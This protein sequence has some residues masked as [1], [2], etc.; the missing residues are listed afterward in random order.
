MDHMTQSEYSRRR[1]REHVAR[2]VS[3]SIVTELYRQWLD[4]QE[5]E[6]AVRE[7][8]GQWGTR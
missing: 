4:R 7:R 8:L 2:M 1:R 5:V 6:R 3:G